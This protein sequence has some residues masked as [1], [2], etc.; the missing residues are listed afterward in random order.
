MLY[1]SVH[2]ENEL[3]FDFS[4]TLIFPVKYYHLHDIFRPKELI[5]IMLSMMKS[6]DK[7]YQKH[8]FTDPRPIN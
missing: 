7:P 2:Q 4:R 6:D 1:V 8:C 5:K 3:R